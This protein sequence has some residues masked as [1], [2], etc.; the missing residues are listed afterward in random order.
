MG[1]SILKFHSDRVNEDQ[2]QCVRPG[3]ALLPL[4]DRLLAPDS[5]SINRI[6]IQKRAAEN[7]FGMLYLKKP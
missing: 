1:F 3:V 5:F 7:V 4:D 2:D 6:E